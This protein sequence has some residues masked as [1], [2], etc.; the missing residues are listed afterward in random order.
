MSRRIILLLSGL[1]WLLGASVAAQEP[2][3][4]RV[5]REEATLLL[6]VEGW[7]YW[8][9]SE[10]IE[11]TRH[12]RGQSFE[13]RIYRQ[14]TSEPT[15]TFVLECTSGPGF[16]PC[17]TASSDGT[18]I[19]LSYEREPLSPGYRV[20]WFYANGTV[21]KSQR[22]DTSDEF[23]NDQRVSRD[24]TIEQ[25][26]E[27]GALIR[28][29]HVT[30]T[31]GEFQSKLEMWHTFAPFKDHQIDLDR[32]IV[33]R[34]RTESRY[35]FLGGQPYRAGDRLVWSADT[36]LQTIDLKTGIR[37]QVPL[38][39]PDETEFDIS[40]SAVTGF[41]GELV[42][43]GSNV[44]LEADTGNRF[45]NWTD[46]RINGLL[47]THARIGYRFWNGA[48]EAI[49]LDNPDRE[50]VFLTKCDKENFSPTKSGIVVWRG[51]EWITV[52]WYDPNSRE[53]AGKNN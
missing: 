34:P 4:I 51:N 24:Y 2:R 9:T 16:N 11:S 33:V 40:R 12:Q 31:P 14:K 10:L 48:L 22:I 21:E 17:Q 38:V 7:A 39:R 36:E 47:F 42:L 18:L 19:C 3:T 50:P 8:R 15:A 29:T 53:G 46:K 20:L 25:A 52:P 5:D 44:V 27:D 13:H 41:D 49:E 28:W 43:L 37:S 32:Q 30:Y 26:Y 23:I 45:T 6:V 1:S 35:Q